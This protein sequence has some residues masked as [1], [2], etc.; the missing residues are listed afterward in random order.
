M[1]IFICPGASPE[2][3]AWG[4]DL[5]N[6][7]FLVFCLRH[8]PRR[9]LRANKNLHISPGYASGQINLHIS[10]EAMLEG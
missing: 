2:D 1:Q 8:T 9:S 10:P 4:Y 7:K 5:E 6:S 3:K